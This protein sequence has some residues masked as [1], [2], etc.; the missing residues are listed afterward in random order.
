[1]I[2]ICYLTKNSD[3]KYSTYLK[4]SCG[5]KNCDV[6]EI[7]D[8]TK[9]ASKI[10]N[11]IINE[12]K[13]NIIVFCEENLEF[14][15]GWGYKILKHFEKNQDFGIIGKVGVKYIPKDGNWLCND[16]S[17]AIGQINIKKN[18]IKYNEPFGNKI[19]DV[20]VVD[21]VFLCIDKNRIKNTFDETINETNFLSVDFCFQ[22]FLNGVKIGVISNFDITREL[23]TRIDEKWE[24]QKNVFANKFKSELP[25]IIP[26]QYN[27]KPINNKQ[28]LVSILMP[29]YNYGNRIN[30][31]LNSI[32][33][34]NYTNFEIIMVDD[35]STDQ[36]IKNKLKLLEKVERI[37]IFYKEN[38]GPS[39][40][41]NLAFRH[42]NGNFILPLDSDDMIKNDFIKICVDILQK[43][44]YISPVYCDAHH[45]GQ[46]T[47]IEKKPEWSPERLI[48]GPFIAN[49]SIFHR[50]AFEKINGYDESLKGWEDYDFWLR[51][52]NEGYVGKRI[53]KDLFVYYH[54]EDDGSIN[55]FVEKNK[56][57]SYQKI[58]RKNFRIENDRLHIEIKKI[59]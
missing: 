4:K 45:I 23:E 39:S 2:T 35:G 46:M 42:S 18:K 12:S 20:I 44:D 56:H 11:R 17:E 33:N 29:V 59:K 47:G 48:K 43:N 6:I 52:M 21:G 13:N 32:F 10:Y 55:S 51:M 14:D 49:C 36:Y 22:N 25:K 19:I 5:I 54:H 40:A 58:I 7:I 34:Q 26:Y 27:I 38:G 31:T 53:P 24:E 50:V 37:K 28:P 41:R 57:E 30:H 8:D 3:Q 9:N 15:N 1:M 16:M